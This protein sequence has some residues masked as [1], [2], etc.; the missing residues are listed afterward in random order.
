MSWVPL[1]P[2]RNERDTTRGTSTA[3][4][5][6]PL[7]ISSLRQAGVG[8]PGSLEAGRAARS[9]GSTGRSG[10]ERVDEPAPATPSVRFLDAEAAAKALKKRTLTKPLQRR[11]RW[12]ADA[13]E[14]RDAAV[15]AA[16]GW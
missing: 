16:Y 13:H 2:L 12:L 15:G 11:P 9:G 14:A 6:K 5:C 10:V 7:V 3:Q 4:C 8:N 1:N